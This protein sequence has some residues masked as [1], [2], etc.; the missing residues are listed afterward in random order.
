MALLPPELWKEIVDFFSD[1]QSLRSLLLVNKT[2]SSFAVRK[3]YGK[4]II[5]PHID[6]N[7][8]ADTISISSAGGGEQIAY[9]NYASLVY[10]ISITSCDRENEFPWFR[11]PPVLAQCPNTNGILISPREQ[12]AE[13]Q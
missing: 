11:L 9:Y 10:T 5:G 8:L 6:F 7:K 12:Y 3:L 1:Y 4:I 13:P 2:F